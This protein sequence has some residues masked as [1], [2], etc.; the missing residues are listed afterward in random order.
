MF[1]FV[2]FFMHNSCIILI[3]KF[4]EV[5]ILKKGNFSIISAVFLGIIDNNNI[6]LNNNNNIVETI[7]A[8]ATAGRTVTMLRHPRRAV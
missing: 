8:G 5:G 1:T 2:G 7:K 6:V 4:I 3:F